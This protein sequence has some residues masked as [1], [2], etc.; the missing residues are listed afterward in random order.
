MTPEEGNE[1]KK[2]V[3]GIMTAILMAG[4]MAGAAYRLESRWEPTTGKQ[5]TKETVQETVQETELQKPTHPAPSQI[6]PFPDVE[7]ETKAEPLIGGKTHYPYDRY[8]LSGR[9][10]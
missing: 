10:P 3:T 4:V 7:K 5:Q 9:I 2:R 1:T 8:T 6:Q